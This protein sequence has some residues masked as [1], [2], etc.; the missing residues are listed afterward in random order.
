MGGATSSPAAVF[1]RATRQQSFGVEAAGP[2]KTVKADGTAL[3]KNAYTSMA[4]LPATDADGGIIYVGGL[5]PGD[6]ID[7]LLFAASYDGSSYGDPNNNTCTLDVWAVNDIGRGGGDPEYVATWLCQLSLVC[8][9]GSVG[10]VTRVNSNAKWVD[11]ITVVDS[12]GA[13]APAVIGKTGADA[14]VRALIDNV[15][16]IGL[17]LGFSG[18]T[19]DMR[20]GAAWAQR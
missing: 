7:L 4:T 8:G 3:A 18:G 9:N 13:T 6:L 19:A 1:S 17:I 5:N 12:A 20:V 14:P 11:T 15:G 2:T 10:S 16:S